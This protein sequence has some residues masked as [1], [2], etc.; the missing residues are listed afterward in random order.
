MATS[1]TA[2]DGARFDAFLSRCWADHAD[3]AAAVA[4]RLLTDTPE[5]VSP[6][7]VAA[8]ARLVVH[9]LG[10]HLGRFDD[11][12]WR[13]SAL[14]G[15][16][17]ATDAV[18]ASELRVA[19]AALSLACLQPGADATL[20]PAERVRALGSAAALCLGRGEVAHS[21]GLIASA[22]SELSRMPA[23][24]AAEHRPLA[25]ACNNMA[26]ELQARGSRRGPEE[27]AAMLEIAAASREHW[28]HAGTWLDVERADYC[29]AITHLSAGRADDALRHAAQCLATCIAHDAPPY[30]L[31]FGH[32]ALARVQQARADMPA[33]LHHRHAA[34]AAF[35]GLDADTQGGCRGTM[36][37]LLALVPGS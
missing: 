12:H 21:L 16:R 27:T 9:L 3:H 10:E 25:V 1:D 32:E 35:D 14:A 31:F 5:P 20:S 22:R 4:A 28:R 23:A 11:A 34:Q 7:Q 37:S 17:L 8:L 26:W 30:E 6:A 29:L 15:H 24:G 36:D 33:A 2:A 19:H 18:A 13:L